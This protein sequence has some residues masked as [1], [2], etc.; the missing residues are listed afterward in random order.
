MRRWLIL[1]GSCALARGVAALAPDAGLGKRGHREARRGGCDVGLQRVQ[2]VE[3]AQVR[4]L[5]LESGS[6]SLHR[7]RVVMICDQVQMPASGDPCGW[8]L[9]ATAEMTTTTNAPA[10]LLS[11]KQPVTARRVSPKTLKLSYRQL[12]SPSTAAPRH[13]ADRSR[14]VE[15]PCLVDIQATHHLHAGRKSLCCRRIGPQ[16]PPSGSRVPVVKVRRPAQEA[17]SRE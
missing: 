15:S 2:P 5:D 3:P 4:S 13:P 7:G 11:G 1:L 12:I 9:A 14:R 6:P 8:R 10:E 16:T 17:T